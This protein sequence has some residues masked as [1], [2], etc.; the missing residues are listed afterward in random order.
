MLVFAAMAAAAFANPEKPPMTQSDRKAQE[1]KTREQVNATRALRARFQADP[2]RP[3][4]HFLNPEG[5]AHAF[6][7]NGAIYWKGRY[8][9]MYIYQDFERPGRD[10]W[11]H[12]SSTDLLHWRIHP[13]ALSPDEKEDQIYSG[14]A[15]VNR[16]GVPTIIYHGTK[17]GKSMG[18]CIALAADDELIRWDKLPE[19]PV[20][21]APQ[22]GDPNRGVYW[23]WDPTAWLEGDTYYAIFGG[24]PKPTLFK[25]SDLTKWE[26][27]GRF[28]E[29]MA[30][31]Q[32]GD[33]SCPD[34]FPL[35]DRHVLV[36]I[37]HN[38][39]LQYIVGRWENEKFT[40]ELHRM[41]NP[42]GG[43]CFASESLLDGRG[44]RILWAWAPETRSPKRWAIDGWGGV[45]TLPRVLTL[46]EDR[47]L[48][49]APV[50]ELERLRLN[51]RRV[52]NQRVEPGLKLEAMS[53]DCLELGLEIEPGTAKRV[54]VKVFAS[55][56]GQ[57]ETLISY[58]VAAGTLGVD[59]TKASL[60]PEVRYGWP[61]PHHSHHAA[62]PA[63]LRVSTLP[64]PLAPGEP[65]RLRVFLDKSILEVFANERQVI[66]QRVYPTRAD[67]KGVEILSE[68]GAAELK[69]ADAWDMVASNPW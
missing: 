11:G 51:Y 3:A 44:R 68:G 53:G 47:T 58:D 33:V 60:D 43:R 36:F 13:P 42:A 30:L 52:E 6:D 18:N 55:P 48:R 5:A 32:G 1:L 16:E 23:T 12:A 35:G 40:P 20:V 14:G 37:S 15:F 67:A 2:H 21:L 63:E 4:Y 8:H 49:V 26:Y 69:R 29:D 9:L 64:L 65:L 61:K 59:V 19:N 50:E 27:R 66:T 46:G 56:D 22:E 31:I 25:S 28:V 57:E 24:W 54:V 17:G 10:F 45:L 39:G 7:P 34:F 41:I 62:Q 38:L